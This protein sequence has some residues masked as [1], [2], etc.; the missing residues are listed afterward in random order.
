MTKLQGATTD[1]AEDGGGSQ[2][3]RTLCSW[4]TGGGDP[5]D[6]GHEDSGEDGSLRGSSLTVMDWSDWSDDSESL[7]VR[8]AFFMGM[9]G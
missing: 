1:H 6:I 7:L 5:G 9:Q 8:V 3:G 4:Y 2:P